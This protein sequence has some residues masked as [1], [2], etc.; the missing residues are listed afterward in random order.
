MFEMVCLEIFRVM[1]KLLTALKSIKKKRKYELAAQQPS[2]ERFLS[3]IALCCAVVCSRRC[4][5]CGL[6]GPRCHNLAFP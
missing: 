5:L 3:E 4:H 1:C 2:R 6:T